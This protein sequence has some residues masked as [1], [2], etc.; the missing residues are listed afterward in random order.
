MGPRGK[1][2][3]GAILLLVGI[4]WYVPGGPFNSAALATSTLTNFQ[5]LTVMVQGGLGIILA[6]VGAFVVWIER[7]ELR[8]RRE[9]ES[10]EFG[11]QVQRSVEAVAEEA[12]TE[13]ES[14]SGYVC[15]EC[16]AEFDSER[17]LHIHQGQK[18]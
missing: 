8:I 3:V 10:R 18:H 2:V 4:W 14:G 11:E 5:S 15:D 7:D 16:G 17:G 9:M 13:T 12:T 1:M 6:L